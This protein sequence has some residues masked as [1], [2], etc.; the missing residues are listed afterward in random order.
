MTPWILLL[1]TLICIYITLETLGVMDYFKEHPKAF[2]TLIWGERGKELHD[3]S[4]RELKRYLI[5]RANLKI[6]TVCV[7][8]TFYLADATFKAFVN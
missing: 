8:I 6:S 1:F 4:P 5:E 3:Q 7:V 2:Y